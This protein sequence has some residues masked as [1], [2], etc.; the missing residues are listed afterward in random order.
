MILH[1]ILIEMG[2]VGKSQK[3]TRRPTQEELEKLKGGLI[4]RMSYRSNGSVRIPFVDILDFSI[5]T[6]MRIGEVCQLRWDDLNVEH[7][8]IVVRDR[9]DPRKKSGNHMIV[10]LLGGSF[11]IV[12]KQVNESELIF[13]YNPRSVTAGFQRVRNDLEIDDLRYQQNTA[14]AATSESNELAF[15]KMRYKLPGK[16]ESTL[17]EQ[18]ITFEDSK[19]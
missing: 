3:R 9:K 7:K 14:N 8:T 4:K 19:Q 18:A 11:D 1:L 17:M 15:L 2:L 12:Q 6:C 13:P 16:T 10:P 5:L